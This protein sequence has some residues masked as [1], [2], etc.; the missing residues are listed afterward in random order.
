[1]STTLRHD[2][3]TKCYSD[4]GN[5]GHLRA[6]KDQYYI[7][8]LLDGTIDAHMYFQGKKV[9]VWT[10]NNYLGLA[11][12]PAI[13]KTALESIEKWNITSAFGSR[14]LTGNSPELLEL[15]N[16]FTH[17]LQKSG[18][19]VANIGY[20]GVI[21]SITAMVEPGDT[22]I[23]DQLSHAC[24]VDAAYLA[25]ARS[26]VKIKP[27]KHNDMHDLER[28]LQLTQEEN[29]GGALIVT[30]GVFGMRGDL[31][32]LKNICAL[33]KQY[34]ARLFVDDAHGIGIMG[35]EGR[36]IG[37]HTGTQ[38]DIDIYFGTFAKAFANIGSVIAADEEVISYIRF[39][40]RPFVFSRTLPKVIIQSV[41]TALDIVQNEPENR[42][43]LWQITYKL[44]NGL[45]E[46]G[47]NLGDTASPITPVYVPN[48][49]EALALKI[50]YKLRE[51]F[52]IF[53]SAVT[54]PV[55]PKG[56][57]LFRMIPT[58][59]HTEEDVEKTL[60]AFAAIRDHFRL[61]LVQ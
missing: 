37:E 5:F 58:T 27:F 59:N 10:I 9:I 50:I 45:R 42:E 38:A 32:D 14:L 6:S 23:L 34:G 25:Q 49:D 7:E 1:M 33:K 60:T 35:K 13:K 21:G 54:Y 47:F 2:L 57:M 55:V 19:Y 24:M 56:I 22:I 16:K 20:L 61:A 26:R 11:K 4:A 46:L 28:Q 18:A 15:E 53:V 12:H 52:G 43:R 3:F 48:G 17:F 31:A 51:E 44:Q 36:G 39:N 40:G 29:T 8:P 41:S 30:E